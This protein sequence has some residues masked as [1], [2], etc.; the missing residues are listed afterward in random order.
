MIIC[1]KSESV[2][3]V[4]AKDLVFNVYKE[5]KLEQQAITSEVRE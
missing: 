1:L 5:L 4:E 3:G 2:F